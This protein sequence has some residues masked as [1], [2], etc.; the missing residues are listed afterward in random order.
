M[1]LTNCPHCNNVVND[2]AS[3]CPECGRPI[4]NI[5]STL[6]KTKKCVVCREK[7]DSNAALC[8]Y[9][10]RYQNIVKRFLYSHLFIALTSIS[11][12]FMLIFAYYQYDEL[13]RKRIAADEAVQLSKA[14]QDVSIDVLKVI[15]QLVVIHDPH[16]ASMVA[17]YNPIA[18][19]KERLLKE[20][21]KVLKNAE[22]FKQKV[23]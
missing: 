10:G 13:R 7:I 18:E 4:A 22:E 6:K 19:H 12:V 21:D 17:N 11:A 3:T 14:A 15:R 2:Q 1:P 16:M 20:I 9:C 5:T 8:R 23:N